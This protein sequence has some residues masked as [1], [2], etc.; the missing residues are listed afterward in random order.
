MKNVFSLDGPLMVFLG[1][2]ADMVILNLLFV[3]CSVPFF[4]IGSSVTALFYVTLKIRDGNN[5]GICGKFFRSF[6]QN[7][8]Q[9]TLIWLSLLLLT[10]VLS[11]NYRFVC[12]ATEGIIYQIMRIIIY[13]CALLLFMV[14]FYVFLLQARFHNS[15]LQTLHNALILAIANAPRCIALAIILVLAGFIM[16]LSEDTFWYGLLF[17]IVIG[18]S[19]LARVSCYILCKKIP[20]LAP[21]ENK[22]I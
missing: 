9:A 4:T 8:R 13:I 2:M 20:G 22:P 7:F 6:K 10:A 15:I 19:A 14:A 1:K 12:S 16:L 3:F 5:G 17:W 18:F 21:D 11:L